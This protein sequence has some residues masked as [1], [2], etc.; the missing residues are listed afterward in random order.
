MNAHKGIF[1]VTLVSQFQLI[2]V[3]VNHG[4]FIQFEAVV[5]LDGNRHGAAAGSIFR[6]DGHSA[7]LRFAGDSHG[8]AREENAG[9]Y[10]LRWNQW[11]C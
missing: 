1:A 5:R 8:I 6:A 11:L 4:E 7:V 10:V 9:R 3:L 2:S